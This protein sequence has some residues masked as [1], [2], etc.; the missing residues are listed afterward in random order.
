MTDDPLPFDP[1]DFGLVEDTLIDHA[2]VAAEVR[3]QEFTNLVNEEIDVDYACMRFH[4]WRLLT[5][6]L[7]KYGIDLLRPSAR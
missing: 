2:L 6:D 4:F 5:D 3:H 7:L 1:E